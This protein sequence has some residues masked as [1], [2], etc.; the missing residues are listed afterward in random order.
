M[1]VFNILFIGLA[2]YSAIVWGFNALLAVFLCGFTV[3]FAVFLLVVR[4][5]SFD[6][7]RLLD[8]RID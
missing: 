6:E 7:T 5:K 4:G 1:A 8:E 2:G 3:N